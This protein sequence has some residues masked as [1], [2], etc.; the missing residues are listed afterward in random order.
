MISL[1]IL[2]VETPSNLAASITSCDTPDTPAKITIKLYPNAFHEVIIHNTAITQPS[3]LDHTGMVIP[4]LLHI[5][6]IG[7]D[8]GFNIHVYKIDPTT[9][10]ITLGRKNMAL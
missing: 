5:I 9:S 7:P 8:T 10:D 1:K 2:S 6:A 3:V 4:K